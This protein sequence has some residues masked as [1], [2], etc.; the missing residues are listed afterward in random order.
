MAWPWAEN[1]TP[2]AMGAGRGLSHKREQRWKKGMEVL[3]PGSGWREAESTVENV[4]A[5]RHGF[6]AHKGLT[7]CRKTKP[8][9]R[10]R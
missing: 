3:G 5:V 10:R 1:E 7:D 4:V 6:C 8:L 9:K 2:C